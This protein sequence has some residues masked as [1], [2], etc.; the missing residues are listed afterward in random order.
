MIARNACWHY[1]KN[2]RNIDRDKPLHITNFEWTTILNVAEIIS[3]EF[4]NCNIVPAD[5][6]DNVQRGIRNEP[7]NYILNFWSPKTELR[8]G[9]KQVIDLM[10]THGTI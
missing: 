5:S 8:N 4:D 1:L 6:K 2:I 3:S 7:D 9:I 10:K